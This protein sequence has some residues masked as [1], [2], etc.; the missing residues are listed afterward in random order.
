MKR[1]QCLLVCEPAFTKI[2]S[3]RKGQSSVGVMETDIRGGGTLETVLF[4]SSLAGQ[5]PVYS[6]VTYSEEL[7]GVRG[8]IV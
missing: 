8:V 6:I 7:V 3:L 5:L 2:M 1:K 4:C